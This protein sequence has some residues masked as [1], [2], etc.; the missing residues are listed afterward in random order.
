MNPSKTHASLDAAGRVVPRS[1]RAGVYRGSKQVVSEDVAV[2]EIHDGEVLIQVAACGICGS[3]KRAGAMKI[4]WRWRRGIS[5]ASW[6]RSGGFRK[7]GCRL[8]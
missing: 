6:R 8:S 2:P 5:Y 4:I 1:M 7:E 3:G